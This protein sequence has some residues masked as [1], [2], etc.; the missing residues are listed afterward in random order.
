[1]AYNVI[2]TP[3][4]YADIDTATEWYD[5]QV[6]D[7]GIDFF[8]EFYVEANYL[9]ENAEVHAFVSKPV[10]KK[11]MSRFPYAIYYSILKKRNEVIN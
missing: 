5:S 2:L 3:Q 4:A 7:L 8:L 11:L 6:V 9:S 1:M 10:R